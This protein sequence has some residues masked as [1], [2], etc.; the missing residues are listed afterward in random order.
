LLGVDKQAVLKGSKR[1]PYV[2]RARERAN[3]RMKALL[4]LFDSR[5]KGAAICKDEKG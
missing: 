1:E 2:A 5:I 4:M 3:P